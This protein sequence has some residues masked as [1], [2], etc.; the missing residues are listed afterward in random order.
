VSTA[1]LRAAGTSGQRVPM[2]A[3]RAISRCCIDPSGSRA[4]VDFGQHTVQ[5]TPIRGSLP[6]LAHRNIRDILPQLHLKL[7]AAR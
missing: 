1:R 4:E 6:I 5:T 2:S 3:A 7:E